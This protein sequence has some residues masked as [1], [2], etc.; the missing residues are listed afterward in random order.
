M[1]WFLTLPPFHSDV[2]KMGFE[3][4]INFT[5]EVSVL[6]VKFL[7]NTISNNS[8]FWRE[9]KQM[10]VSLK[11]KIGC[12]YWQLALYFKWKSAIKLHSKTVDIF[13]CGLEEVWCVYIDYIIV[14]MK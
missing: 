1:G 6:K 11:K 12:M 5:L 10:L 8:H 3:M 2:N 9:K 14:A 13:P 7:S 4:L